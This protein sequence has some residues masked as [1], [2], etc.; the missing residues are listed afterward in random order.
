MN[1][2]PENDE[3]FSVKLTGVAGGALLSPNRSSVQLRIRPNDSP[4]R[5]SLAVMAVSESVGVIALNLT[6]GQLTED[7]PLI[8]SL[9]TQVCLFRSKFIYMF[10]LTQATCLMQKLKWIMWTLYSLGVC[11]L[12]CSE[13]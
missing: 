8:G 5:F 4:L 6:R 10:N 2:I 7:G 1:Q 13:R 9:D 11:G 12:H 3:V